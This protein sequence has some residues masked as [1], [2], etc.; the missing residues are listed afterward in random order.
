MRKV[1]GK[2]KDT[3]ESVEDGEEERLRKREEIKE[4]REKYIGREG[5]HRKEKGN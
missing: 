4:K 3:W 1:K 5:R 2:K